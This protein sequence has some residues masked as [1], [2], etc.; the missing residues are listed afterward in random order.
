MNHKC[1]IENIN[2]I[3]MISDK[4]LTKRIK[5]EKLP[6]L[7]NHILLFYILPQDGT[8]LLFNEVANIWDISKSSL[9]DIIIK[10]E[11]QD[12]IK[13]C[14]CTEDKRSVYVSLTP[15]ALYIREKLDEIVDEF[16]KLLLKGFDQNQCDT[17]KNDVNKALNNI[18]TLRKS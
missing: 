16:L 9:S 13:K 12:L 17:F 15:Q 7:T 14:M 2:Q 5:E 6:I 3:S 18:D 1:I 11:N 8:P 4:F 10:Y